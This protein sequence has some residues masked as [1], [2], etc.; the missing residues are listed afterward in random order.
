MHNRKLKVGTKRNFY[1]IIN[2]EDSFFLG[3]DGEGYLSIEI[4]IILLLSQGLE[5]FNTI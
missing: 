4:D 1:L 2:F 3:G 5:I